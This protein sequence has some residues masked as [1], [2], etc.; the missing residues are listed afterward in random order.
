MLNAT[1]VRQKKAESSVDGTTLYVCYSTSQ[2]GANHKGKDGKYS[3]TYNHYNC[4]P[5]V[6]QTLSVTSR[7][8]IT[9]SCT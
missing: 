7:K 6:R 2:E 5:L 4:R 9:L 3:R 8:S 1:R